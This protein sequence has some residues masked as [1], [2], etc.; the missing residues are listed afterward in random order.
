MANGRFQEL[1]DDS[2]AIPSKID[3]VVLCS[4]KFY[5][6]LI[7]VYEKNSSEN[8]AFI[9]LEQLYSISRY[10]L[11]SVIKKYGKQS[12]YIWAQEEPENMGPWSY[13]LR[14]WNYSNITCFQ[15]MSLEVQLLVLQRFM[16]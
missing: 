13:I 3:T 14:K 4:G 15:E 1:I 5:Y 16:K 6:D 2:K 10:Q 9:R 12:Q 8:M 11:K 7:E